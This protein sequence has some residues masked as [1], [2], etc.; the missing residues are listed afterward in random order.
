MLKYSCPRRVVDLLTVVGDVAGTVPKS[1]EEGID[2]AAESVHTCAK[3]IVE[4]SNMSQRI[5]TEDK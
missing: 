4:V 5:L 3:T 1:F 2:C